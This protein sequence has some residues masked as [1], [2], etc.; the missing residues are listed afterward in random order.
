MN[1]IAR[2]SQGYLPDEKRWGA[3]AGHWLQD[4]FHLLKRTL[5]NTNMKAATTNTNRKY[6]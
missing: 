3:I 4:V 2:L 1:S 6:K 5:I